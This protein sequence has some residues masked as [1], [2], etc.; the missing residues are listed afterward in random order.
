[1]KNIIRLNIIQDEIGVAE[2]PILEV[3]Y[4]DNKKIYITMGEFE[5]FLERINRGERF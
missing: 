1:M 2:E 4:E 5:K 3:V